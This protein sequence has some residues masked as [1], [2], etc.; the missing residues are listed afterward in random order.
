MRYINKFKPQKDFLPGSLDKNGLNQIM[1][2]QFGGSH[3]YCRWMLQ[4]VKFHPLNN[5][6]AVGKQ[7]DINFRLTSPNYRIKWQCS[8]LTL[9]PLP[10]MPCLD[11]GG[12]VLQLHKQWFPILILTGDYGRYCMYAFTGEPTIYLL[13]TASSELTQTKTHLRRPNSSIPSGKP[14]K[15]WKIT[16]LIGTSHY[17]WLFPMAM[18]V[19]SRG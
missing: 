19:I 5:A 6:N 18:L 2:E 14:I 11:S 12:L 16:S 3:L 10:A 15:L 7:H 13:G 4:R 17:K 1:V 8:P 9:I